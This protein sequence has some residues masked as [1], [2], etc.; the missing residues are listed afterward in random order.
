ML[1]DGFFCDTWPSDQIA[2]FNSLKERRFCGT[3]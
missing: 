3:E 2:F 1:V